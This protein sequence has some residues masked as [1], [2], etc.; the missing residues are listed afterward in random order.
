MMDG[1]DLEHCREAI[2]HGSL[3]FHAASRLLPARVRDPALALYAFCRLADDEVDLKADKA[4]S[5]LALRE[6]LDLAYAG[7]PR[8]AAP[9]RAFTALIEEYD[10]PRALPEALL[11]GLAWDAME[12]R[13]ASLSDL[14]AYSARV[15]SAVGAM[16]CVL[17]RVRCE[18]ALA[19]ACDLGVAMQLTN[20]ARDVGEDAAE[21]RLYLPTDWLQDAGLAPDAF[22]ADPHPSEALRAVVRR[23]LRQAD[24]LYARSESGIAALPAD[25]RPGIYAARH[26]YAGI[27][28]R[29]RARGFDSVTTRARTG[30]GRKLGWL[31]LSMVRAGVTLVMP[32][33]ATIYARP[34]PEVAFLV[35]AAACPAPRQA[36]WSDRVVTLLGQLEAQ[37]RA[38]KASL[39]AAA[40]R[41]T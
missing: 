34:L 20:I 32:R 25:C 12:R 2:R 29:V 5:V 6:R 14:H 10:M 18:H 16:M 26:I 11:E 30:R 22:L 28:G 21:G 27:G 3:S 7:R 17:M 9:D 13:Y 23:L 39:Q 15:A 36:D 8:N 1:G 4:A 19:R 35:D 37:D 24:A 41:S 40:A 38:Q 33:P 31:G